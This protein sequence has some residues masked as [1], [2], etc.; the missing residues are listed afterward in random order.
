MDEYI[1]INFKSYI[2]SVQSNPAL[3]FVIYT[4]SEI[5]FGIIP[6][7]FFMIL[8]I[9]HNIS[10]TGFSVN[11]IIYATLSYLSGVLGYYIGRTFSKTSIYKRIREKYLKQYEARLKAFGSYLVFVGA[12]TP[13]PFSATCMMAGSVELPFK[14]FLLICSARVLRFGVYGW[15][16]WN[17][18]NWFGG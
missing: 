14:N 17:F 1:R 9:L 7:E 18:P 16:V 15:M 5:V 10:V 12:V 13:I 3:L 2:D 11:L 6:P 8:S 4:L